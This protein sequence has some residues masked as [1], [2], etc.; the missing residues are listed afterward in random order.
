MA[1]GLLV[2]AVPKK[3][4]K[5]VEACRVWSPSV[6]KLNA[7]VDAA[8]D[9]PKPSKWGADSRPLG[10]SSLSGWERTSASTRKT[11]FS[12]GYDVNA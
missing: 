5:V 12:L 6:A 4:I 7:R 3:M 1:Q 9:G 11:N 8:W 2:A 10:L